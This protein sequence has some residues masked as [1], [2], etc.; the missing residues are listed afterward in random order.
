M[1]VQG[2]WRTIPWLPRCKMDSFYLRRE[3]SQVIRIELEFPNSV[4]GGGG[5]GYPLWCCGSWEYISIYAWRGRSVWRGLKSWCKS[6]KK[7][8][9]I[10]WFES[11]RQLSNVWT[12]AYRVASER[13]I[14][15]TKHQVGEQIKISMGFSLVRL[16]VEL[17]I[18][19]GENQMCTT[20]D[21]ETRTIDSID[22]TDKDTRNLSHG[23]FEHLPLRH[24]QSRTIHPTPQSPHNPSI[25]P[26]S[27]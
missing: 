3:H 8:L 19:P 1:L 4:R 10:I 6:C 17:S 18:E 13:I 11:L 22:S 21:D 7:C 23:D 20:T 14:N 9:E 24:Y 27:L 12:T 15:Q 2:N 5:R 26:Q 16:P 25:S